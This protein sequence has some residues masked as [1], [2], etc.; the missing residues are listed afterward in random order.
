MSRKRRGWPS[1]RDKRSSPI[2][3]SH[4]GEPD[5][6]SSSESP[7]RLDASSVDAQLRLNWRMWV[8]TGL[9]VGLLVFAVLMLLVRF[10]QSESADPAPAEHSETRLAD[11]KPSGTVDDSSQLRQAA[12][13]PIAAAQ[14]NTRAGTVEPPPA[15]SRSMPQLAIPA[16]PNDPWA[17]GE[18]S[19]GQSQWNWS[20]GSPPAVTPPIV[21]GTAEPQHA[22]TPYSGTWS[23]DWRAEASTA[24]A[25]SDG[26]SANANGSKMMG[27]PGPLLGTRPPVAQ[28]LPAAQAVPADAANAHWPQPGASA[29]SGQADSA[30]TE[31][32]ALS[33]QVPTWPKLQR[34][35]TEGLA[36]GTVFP[37][38]AA[39][40]RSSRVGSLPQ[41]PPASGTTSMADSTPAKLPRDSRG[42]SGT[43]Q[44]TVPPV[45]AT[46]LLGAGRA[47]SGSMS[48]P[49]SRPASGSA[50]RTGSRSY[51]VRPGETVFDIAR[52]QLGKPQRWVEIVEMNPQLFQGGPVSLERIPAGTSL[53]LP[54]EDA[55]PRRW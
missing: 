4:Q 31:R 25:T 29:S 48:G 11:A 36:S 33:P 3:A 19:S 55:R 16:G 10:Q 38:P 45:P 12:T 22:S 15:M 47:A 51:T 23:S 13:G 2:A 9:G 18:Q 40:S 28:P 14:R 27:T 26:R 34:E 7:Q 41:Q 8:G 1:Q 43:A 54:A 6:L 30:A 44:V 39:D 24:A 52:Q 17:T 42:V 37:G 49:A 35:T 5:D 21:P 53:L 20:A 50:S 32:R 46:E